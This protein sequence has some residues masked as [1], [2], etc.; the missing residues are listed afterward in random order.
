[1]SR[2]AFP[3]LM[4]G[5]LLA[6]AC[7][8]RPAEPNAESAAAGEPDPFA[9][10]PHEGGFAADLAWHKKVAANEIR[11]SWFLHGDPDIA[12]VCLADLAH[13]KVEA[14][15]E[16]FDLASQGGGPRELSHE[17]VLA[18][19]E[20]SGKLPASCKPPELKD[21]ILVSVMRDGKPMI[22]LYNRLGHP[23]EI[24]RLYDLTG[25]YLDTEPVTEPPAQK[26][27]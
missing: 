7:L 15:R 11:M 21:L 22:R 13:H 18:L 8:H 5:L 17:Q 2:L 16:V 4:L 10:Y 3:L 1:M 24:V 25:A 9:A 23:N 26:K 27:K 12:M 14:W 20:L 19:R 6:P